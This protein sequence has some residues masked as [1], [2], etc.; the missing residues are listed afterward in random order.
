MGHPWTEGLDDLPVF[1]LNTVLMPG[2]ILP[3]HVF[4]PRYRDLVAWCRDHHGYFAIGTVDPSR[5]EGAHGPA[6][7]DILGVGRIVR[8]LP[9]EDGRCNLLLAHEGTAS[10]RREVTREDEAF[11]RLRLEAWPALEIG[12]EVVDTGLMALATQVLARLDLPIDTEP[13]MA[14]RGG[15]W[16]EAMGVVFVRDTPR[17]LA[18]LRASTAGERVALLESS[19]ADVL[20]SEGGDDAYD[21]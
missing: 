1:V 19:L 4:E 17:R 9:Q 3:L 11:R 6:I 5:P 7:H 13:L 8:F 16:L 14:R 20:V 18:W 21:A 12:D 10:V 15:D 2:E